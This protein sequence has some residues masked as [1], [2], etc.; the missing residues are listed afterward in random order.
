M[1]HAKSFQ[2]VIN[3]SK[4]EISKDMN[5]KRGRGNGTTHRYNDD[6]TGYKKRS[7]QTQQYVR[8]F[9][10]EIFLYVVIFLTLE[11]NIN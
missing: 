3:F 11:N 10:L 5:D 4:L 1:K 7:S 9:K 8:S 6:G 2:A